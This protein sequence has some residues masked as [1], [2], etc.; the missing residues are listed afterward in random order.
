MVD[1]WD[2][3]VQSPALTN[4]GWSKL[5]HQAFEKNIQFFTS[6][7][8]SP[9]AQVSR[10]D[11][12]T[13]L[14]SKDNSPPAND[15]APLPI[16]ALHIRRGDFEGHCKHLAT[17][18]SNFNAINSLPV[19]A[20]HDKFVAPR[21]NENAKSESTPKL[22]ARFD[23]PLEVTSEESKNEVYAKHCYPDIPQIVKRVREVVMDYQRI[24]GT[25]TSEVDKDSP[26]T[27][28][29]VKK[30]DRRVPGGAAGNVR[31]RK[32]YIMTN[33]DRQWLGDV[34]NALM[35]DAA[36]SANSDAWEY[37]EWIWEDVSTSRDLDLGWE[38]KYVAQSLDMYVAQ[39]AELFVG[40]GVSVSLTFVMIVL[41]FSILVLELDVQYRYAEA[42]ERP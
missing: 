24:V 31:L 23:D 21:V 2:T 18:S 1:I 16:L 36:E 14:S 39:R 3:I 26:E 22:E 5:M 13:W 38:E 4:W 17:W 10:R 41:K 40:N 7:T 20:D 27:G 33:G 11:W 34:K 32:V 19:F 9:S 35:K 15:S 30:D 37:F 6:Q 12:V 25:S 42:E 29:A 8:D 28:V